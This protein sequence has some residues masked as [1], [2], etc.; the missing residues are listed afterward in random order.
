ML[1]SIINPKRVEKGPFKMFFIGIVYGALSL[2][3]VHWLFSSDPVLSKA[4]GMIVVAFCLMFSFPFMYYLIKEEEEHDEE[5]ED[6]F[7]VWKVHKNAIFAFIWLF[8]GFVI[9]FSAVHIFMQDNNLLNFQIQT[10]CQINEPGNIKN[11]VERHSFTGNFLEPTGNFNKMSR[12]LSIIQNN[13]FVMIFTLIFS[14]IFGAGAIFIL[15]WNAS[16]IAAAVGI[17]SKYEL[18]NL[19]VGLLRYM[20]HGIPEIVAYFITALAGGIFGLGVIKT[21]MKTER[22]FRILED[23]IALLFIALVILIIAAIIEVYLTPI[24]VK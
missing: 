16:V 14:I 6:F 9:S 23:S 19:P 22:F 15:I 4:S 2:L 20:I 5:L 8:L 17:F 13:V 24:L 7:N 21:K 12:F 18:I 11:C 10:Y 1:E 3:L